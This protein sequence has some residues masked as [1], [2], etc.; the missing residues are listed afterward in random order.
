MSCRDSSM[1]INMEISSMVDYDMPHRVINT[2]QRTITSIL[3]VYHHNHSVLRRIRSS[4]YSATFPG[5]R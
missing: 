2:V 1:I 3:L 5:H 4:E